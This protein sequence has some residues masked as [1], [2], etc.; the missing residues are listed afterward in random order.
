MVKAA[1]TECRGP[2]SKS[3]VRQPPIRTF[4][5]NLTVMTT[6]L[7][8]GRW[9]LQGLGKLISWARMS[10]KPA[11]SMAMVLKKGK[12]VDKFSFF[13]ATVRLQLKGLLL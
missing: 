8:G 6:L 11:K 1:E 3:G 5:D 4:M 10:F 9:I 13:E 2:V 7:P 12:V